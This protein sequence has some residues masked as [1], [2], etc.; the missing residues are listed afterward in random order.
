MKGYEI[1]ISRMFKVGRLEKCSVV[2]RQHCGPALGSYSFIECET[3]QHGF[4]VFYCHSTYM[5]T[6]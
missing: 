1:V 3:R 5:D 6:E 4:V 2:A